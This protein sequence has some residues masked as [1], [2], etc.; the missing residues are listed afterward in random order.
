MKDAAS[1]T[2]RKARSDAW[3]AAL[4][5]E[6]AWEIFEKRKRLPWHAVAK[7]LRE[8]KGLD[9]S[10]RALER[11]EAWMRP[12]AAS[13]RVELAVL[14]RQEAKDLAAAAGA[15]QEV[16]DAFLALGAEFALRTEDPAAAGEWLRM[17][18]ELVKAAQKDAELK[19]RE[20]DTRLAREKFEAAEKRLAAVREACEGAK[21]APGGLTPET[22]RKI[23]EA[24]GLL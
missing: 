6:E 10:R 12:Q 4:P 16:A 15:R 3:W 8:S 13:R 17:S 1:S 2:L 9:V 23:E 14:A 20:E 18:A 24:A 22:L 11:F 7:W 21:A 19:L 5:E